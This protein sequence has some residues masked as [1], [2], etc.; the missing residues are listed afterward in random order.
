MWGEEAQLTPL[1]S[2][3]PAYIRCVS[4]Q[5]FEGEYDCF[6]FNSFFSIIRTNFQT[7]RSTFGLAFPSGVAGENAFTMPKLIN[8]RYLRFHY[9]SRNKIEIIARLHLTSF[10][11]D[12]ASY[13]W[14]KIQLPLSSFS[15]FHISYHLDISCRFCSIFKTTPWIEFQQMFLFCSRKSFI[16]DCPTCTRTL[17]FPR[18]KNVDIKKTADKLKIYNPRFAVWAHLAQNIAI[19][20]TLLLE[21][22]VW[23]ACN[24]ANQ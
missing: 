4:N 3:F 18:H 17:G 10:L 8:I 14:I 21:W 1:R 22:F 11:S 2:R 7:V 19:I 16:S 12:L 24:G 15:F 20:F 13:A 23:I 9:P 5:C 6:I